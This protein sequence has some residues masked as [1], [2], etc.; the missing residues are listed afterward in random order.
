MSSPRTV[1]KEL[2]KASLLL[3]VYKKDGMVTREHKYP[4]GVTVRGGCWYNQF[5][6]DPLLNDELVI[7]DGDRLVPT[8]PFYAE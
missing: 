1:Q 4:M 6:V 5:I 2:A 3:A 7:F 8:E